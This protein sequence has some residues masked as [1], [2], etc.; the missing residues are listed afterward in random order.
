MK[1][2]VAASL[3]ALLLG[4]A[5]L[6][7]RPVLAQVTPVVRYLETPAGEKPRVVVTAD[8]ELDDSNS[9]VRYL[10][11]SADYR[12][13]GLIYASSKYHW[14][15]D[16]QGTTQFIPGRE[17]TARGLTLC[18]CTSWRWG[19]RE[20]FIDDAVA[21]YREVYENLAVHDPGYPT[22]ETLQSKIRWGN[23]DFDGEMSKDTPGSDLIKS[24]LLDDEDSPV[25]LLA[26]G[27][28]STIA[29]ALKSIEDEYKATPQ[30]PAIR[31]RVIAKAIIHPSGDQDDTYATYIR[32]SWP[33]IRYGSGG[34]SRAAIAFNAADLASPED[35]VYFSAAWMRENVSNK[36]PMGEFYR[37]WGDGKQ[38][39]KGDILDPFGFADKTEQDMV[40]MGYQMWTPLRE[41]GSFTG[42]GDT[43]TF[44]SLLDD[45]L[46][47]YRVENRPAPVAPPV[48]TPGAAPAPV[49]S[50]PPWPRSLPTRRPTNPFLA[51]LQHDLAAR[52]SWSVT[53]LYEDANHP[54]QITLDALRVSARPGR[55]VSLSATA[56]DPDGDAVSIRWWRFEG[57]GSYVGAVSLVEAEG[58]ITHIRVPADAKP[59]DT[60][61]IVAE[62]TDAGAPSLTRYVQAIVTVR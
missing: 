7:A 35:A 60:F 38:M 43:G 52:L 5:P 58:S 50:L 6:I 17:Y 51:P 4:S 25:Y 49:M 28:Q 55:T 19:E 13:E 57:L 44:M 20:Q 2:I 1:S 21:R 53:P 61:H 27:G 3:G 62:A 8:P 37:V 54:P 14:K 24:L 26:W 46:E 48:P 16:G 45:G 47:G 56:R 34:G 41:K 12:T 30:W 18:P 15:G 29:R 23:V 22:P 40:A 11:H 39:A 31:A 9:L 33:E 59:G 32:P 10:L 36:G 42:E